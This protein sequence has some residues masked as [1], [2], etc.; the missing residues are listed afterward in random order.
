[1]NISS[2]RVLWSVFATY[3][4]SLTHL[5]Q[6]G[7]PSHDNYLRITRV[8]EVRGQLSLTRAVPAHIEEDLDDDEY[9][10]HSGRER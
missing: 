5:M 3:I 8:V 4:L 6:V 9:D 10:D 2:A 7:P 1:M